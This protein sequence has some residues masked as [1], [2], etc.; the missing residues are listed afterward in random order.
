MLT[1]SYIV[2]TIDH[3]Y[4]KSDEMGLVRSKKELESMKEEREVRRQNEYRIIK[5][6]IPVALQMLPENEQIT[7][8]YKEIAPKNE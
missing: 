4:Y 2:H 1:P 5:N 3:I 7:A 6:I 8:G